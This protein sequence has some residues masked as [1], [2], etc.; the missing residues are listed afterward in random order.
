MADSS[1]ARPVDAPLMSR[2]S[3]ASPTGTWRDRLALVICTEAGVLERKS[4]LLV[5]TIRAFGGRFSG[6]PMLSYSPR[7][8][9]L[10]ARSTLH[11]LRELEVECVLEPLNRELPDYGFGNK[12]VACAHAAT[13]L[14]V[15]RLVFLD[16]DMCILE[17]PEALW[18][19]DSDT[20]K[21]RPVDQKLA[22]TDGTDG[23][24]T[25]WERVLGRTGLEGA[26]GVETSLTR[27]EIVGYWNAGVVSAGTRSGFFQEWKDTLLSL[28]EEDEVHPGGMTFMDQ[29]ALAVV[30]QRS[31]HPLEELPFGYNVNVGAYALPPEERS[32][33]VR[34]PLPERIVA[35]HYHKL[36]DAFPLREP[37]SAFAP[38]EIRDE[39]STLVRRSGLAG[40]LPYLRHRLHARLGWPVPGP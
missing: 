11:A 36:L 34:R 1:P 18:A 5:R 37:L 29:I 10:P 32:F 13:I 21:L 14:S 15:E 30:V 23:N 20:V 39:L 12:V 8:G 28:V 17:E 35:A 4:V 19:E 2:T 24:A 25:Y 40:P 38:E 7:P 9:R 22:G 3:N 33:P 6:C 27:E 31:G 26:R 16:S